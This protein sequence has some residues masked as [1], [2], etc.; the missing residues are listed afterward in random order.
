MAHQGQ[1]LIQTV[2][3]RESVY[4]PPWQEEALMAVAADSLTLSVLGTHVFHLC[5]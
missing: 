3:L 2:K 4:S 5:A 1:C